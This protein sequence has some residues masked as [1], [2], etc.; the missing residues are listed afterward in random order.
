MYM[1]TIINLPSHGEQNRLIIDHMG[2]V[3]II[4]SEFRGAKGISFDEMCA[5]G[6]VGLVLAARKFRRG[7]FADYATQS[8]RNK[9]VDFI[10]KW[11]EFEPFSDGDEFERHF[12]EWT[13]WASAVP[14]EKWG[15]LPATPEQLQVAFEE[16][17][18][19]ITALNDSFNFLSERE[20]HMLR[21]RFFR[22]PQQE[23]DSI[24]RDWKISRWRTTYIIN[25]A[26]KKLRT[27]MENRRRKHA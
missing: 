12:Y 13:V 23:M 10:S 1:G 21:A 9:L 15:K 27:A 11:Q 25:R 20:R 2:L 19:D 22:K 7:T 17:R 3:E 16:C 18:S 8:I 6:R 26:L 5:E 4:A 14:A 24:A